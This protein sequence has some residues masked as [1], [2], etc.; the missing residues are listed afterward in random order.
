MWVCKEKK[1]FKWIYKV[2]SILLICVLCI[3]FNIFLKYKGFEI[4]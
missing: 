2:D 3:I 1:F 4:V